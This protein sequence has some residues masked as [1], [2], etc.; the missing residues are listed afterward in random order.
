MNYINEYHKTTT[1]HKVRKM[2]EWQ[3]S[4][5]G[6]E[7]VIRQARLNVTGTNFHRP[8]TA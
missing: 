8:H 6:C 5:I 1:E 7:E 4:P 3:K 2:K